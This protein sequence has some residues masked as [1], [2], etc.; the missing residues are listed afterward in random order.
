MDLTGLYQ[1][2][3]LG[4]FGSG[5]TMETAALSMG[6][7]PVEC[8]WVGPLFNDFNCSTCTLGYESETIGGANG[9]AA[10]TTCIKPTFRPRKG[11]TGRAQLS[12]QDHTGTKLVPDAATNT[13]VTLLTD[14]TYTIPAPPLEPKE[15]SFVGYELPS[16]KIYYEL[17]FSLGAEVDFGCG[18]PVFG[19]GTHDASHVP[20]TK[21]NIAHPLSMYSHQWSYVC[22]QCPFAWSMGNVV[23]TAISSVGGSRDQARHVC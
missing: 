6:G 1:A 12:L 8:L 9:T 19:D 21:E 7:N 18:T 11:W 16:S 4:S 13:P 22:L 3:G 10:T 14:Q 5:K 15:R 20:K 23:M 2:A 17:D